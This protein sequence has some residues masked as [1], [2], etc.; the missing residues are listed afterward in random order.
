MRHPLSDGRVRWKTQSCGVDAGAA[1]HQHMSIQIG[2]SVDDAL[3][4]IFLVLVGGAQ[5]HADERQCIVGGPGQIPCPLGI[6]VIAHRN[7]VAYVRC[8]VLQ[9]LVEG[10]RCGD[11]DKRGALPDLVEK[12]AAVGLKGP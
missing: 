12:R 10:R 8:Q 7:D 11:E 4:E 3:Q 1:H 2:A 5:A 6:A 9:R